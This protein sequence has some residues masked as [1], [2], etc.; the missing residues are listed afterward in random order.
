MRIFSVVSLLCFGVCWTSCAWADDCPPLTILTSVP[1]QIGADNRPYVPVKIDDKPKSMVID[2]G[3][4]FT[5]ISQPVA[6][7]LGLSTRHTRLQL[8]GI[9]G[10][11]TQTAVTTSLVLGHLR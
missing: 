1:M 2:T 6:D 5:E 9:Y 11:K 8:I 10:D 4:F 3:G 7:E